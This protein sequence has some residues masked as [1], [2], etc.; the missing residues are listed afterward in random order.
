MLKLNEDVQTVGLVDFNKMEK[1]Y[2]HKFKDKI[3]YIVDH[4]NDNEL[5]KTTCKE[6][7]I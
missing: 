1:L 6:R 2:E 3:H 5:Y 7:I 4:H